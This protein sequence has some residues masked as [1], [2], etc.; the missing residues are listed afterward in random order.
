[1]RENKI[2]SVSEATLRRLPSYLHLLKKMQENGEEIVSTTYIA[3]ELHLDPTQVR[4]DLAHTS[5]QG[6]P[7]IGYYVSELIDSIIDFLDWRNAS[8][9]FLVGA[10]SLGNALL[11]YNRLKNYGLNIVAAFDVDRDKVGHRAHGRQVLH[12]AKLPELARRMH[13]HIGIITTPADAAQ[14]VADLMIEG[15]IRAIWNFAPASLHLPDDIIV[16]RADLYTSLAILTHKL[17][18]DLEEHPVE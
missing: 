3:K 9:A 5:I 12:I 14:T 6:R 18:D 2:K 13:I 16:Q 4:K 7:K 17:H 1:M 15:G 8:D 10:G 11:G